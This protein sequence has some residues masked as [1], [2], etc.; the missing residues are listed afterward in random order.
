MGRSPSWLA[1]LLLFLLLLPAGLAGQ[2]SG[3][4]DVP[5][6]LQPGDVLHVQVWRQSE[7]SGDF[8]VTVEGRISHPLYRQIEVAGREVEEV[9]EDITEFL[10]QFV[11]QPSIVVEGRV[12]VPVGGEVRQPDIYDLRLDTS[13]ARAV[14]MAGGP[15]DRGAWDD[16]RIRRNGQEY[17]LD[18]TDPDTRLR[19]LE[20][21]SGD[22]IVVERRTDMFRDYIAPSASIV[23]AAAAVLRLFF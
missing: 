13:V 14:A 9:E 22:E 20:V 11:E 1:P 8:E 17:R 10:R 16:V 21:R 4:Y 2:S 23:G 3:F 5:A 19:E 7:F 6:V 18:L 15:T 12:R